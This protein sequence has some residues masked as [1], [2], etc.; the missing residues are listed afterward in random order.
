MRTEDGYSITKAGR[1]FSRKTRPALFF[2]TGTHIKG[3]RTSATIRLTMC[4]FRV[5]TETLGEFRYE[6]SQHRR[7]FH[8]RMNHNRFSI[9]SVAKM[10]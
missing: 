9:A 7:I 1:V 6:H 5:A 8:C 4:G 10:R 2:A 3:A